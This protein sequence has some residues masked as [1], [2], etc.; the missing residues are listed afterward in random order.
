MRR[1]HY[2]WVIA[3]ATFVVFLMT[4]GIRATPPL[5]RCRLSFVTV[6]GRSLVAQPASP[7]PL[8]ATP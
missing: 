5:P 6:G 3:A 8:T 4:A 7:A 2:P 1:L